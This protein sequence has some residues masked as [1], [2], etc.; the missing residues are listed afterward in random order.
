MHENLV[1]PEVA[2]RSDCILTACP[3]PVSHLRFCGFQQEKPCL[4]DLWK[5]TSCLEEYV[6]GKLRT[7]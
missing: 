2:R 7:E 4:G 1:R 5:K 3:F 6:W